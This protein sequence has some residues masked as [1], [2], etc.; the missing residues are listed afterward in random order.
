MAVLGPLKGPQQWSPILF[1]RQS[2]PPV[3]ANHKNDTF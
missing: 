1:N 2:E 3:A